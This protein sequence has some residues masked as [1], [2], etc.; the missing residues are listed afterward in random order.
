MIPEATT[1]EPIG[2]HGTPLR[3]LAPTVCAVVLLVPIAVFEIVVDVPVPRG[4][5]L[6]Y[7]PVSVAVLA[8]V[9]AES[10]RWTRGSALAVALLVVGL[11]VLH[12]VPWS[13]R[14]AFLAD[15]DRVGVGMTAGEVRAILADHE[16]LVDEVH[17]SADGDGVLSYRH[18]SVARY[19]ADIGVVTFEGGV[20]VGTG[21]HPD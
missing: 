6:V 14:K 9:V 20:V 11:V 1:R 8:A 17:T 4:I 15:L 16:L 12:L 10:R 2:G 21:F 7:T 3:F 19:D 5:Y 18:S 13:S